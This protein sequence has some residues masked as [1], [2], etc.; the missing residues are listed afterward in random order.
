M[1]ETKDERS[2]C[3][4]SSVPFGRRLA[5]LDGIRGIAVLAIIAYH[6]LRVTG[7]GGLVLHAWRFVQESTWSGVDLFFVLSG[8]L[9]TGILLDSTQGKGYF[10]N[11]YAR[12]ALRIMPLYYATLCLAL[13]VV[14][15]ALGP[16]RLPALYSRLTSNQLWLWLYLQNY[17]QSHGEHQLPGFG[18]FWTLAVEEQFYWVWPFVVYFVSRRRLL[19]LCLAVCLAEPFVRLS[20]LHIG[21]SGW[22]VRELTPTRMDTLL[23]GALVAILIRDKDLL[24]RWRTPLYIAASAS[25]LTLLALTRTRGFLLY[26]APEMI[27]AGYSLFALLFAV[28][29]LTSA[30]NHGL[31]GQA[32]SAPALRWF[33]KYSYAL[34]IVHPIVYLGYAAVLAPRLAL[35]RFPAAIACFLVVTATSGLIAWISWQLLESRFLRL[36]KYFEYRSE[37][38]AA[39]IRTLH[40][41]PSRSSRGA[42]DRSGLRQT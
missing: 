32:L 10:R 8:F 38:L 3:L 36:K 24:A 22:A 1:S 16:S 15:L 39:A 18:H 21:V 29:I 27:V 4:E 2:E 34:Y 9:I 40:P 19:W 13:I 28:L 25:A 6:T 41:T 35:P 42:V 26:G 23:W 17:L 37:P 33:G 14:P 30:E 20:L 11:F 31:L 5:P 12:R 7:D